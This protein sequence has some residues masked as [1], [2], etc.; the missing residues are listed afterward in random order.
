M[1]RRNF[2][3]AS[4]LSATA[5]M[6]GSMAS[7]AALLHSQEVNA[8]TNEDYKALV[9]VFLYG[10]MDNHDTIIPYDN[11]SYRQ[12]AQ[13]R[14]SLLSSYQT[15]RTR[16]NLLPLVSSASRFGERRFA[17]PPEMKGLQQLYQQGSMAVMGNVGP[18]LE[19]TS[20]DSINN[21]TAKL[22]ARLF[23]HND[24]QST[25]MS[26]TTEGAQLGW[27]GQLNDTL[28]QSGQQSVSTFSAITTS[29]AELLLTGAQ[30]TPFHVQGG[31]AVS[32]DI[33]DESDGALQAQLLSHFSAQDS[34]KGALIKRDLATKNN[35][36]YAANALYNQALSANSGGNIQM[37]RSRLGNQLGAVA[38]TI[39]ARSQ[40][41]SKRQIFM[42]ALGGFDTHSEQAQSLPGLQKMLDEAIVGFYQNM[43]A[44]DLADK[45]TLFTA[46]DFGRTLAVNGDGT[47][48]GWGAHHFVVGG[49]VNGGHIYGDIPPATFNHALDAGSG[50]LIPTTS[51]EQYAANFGAWLGLGE[52]ELASVF[53]NL[54][55]FNERPTLFQ[56]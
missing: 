37:P 38:K 55:N 34:N 17:L 2:L 15:P 54:A 21:E 45:V 24:Q 3:K 19:T 42:V 39:N 36:A 33:L 50:R 35:Q 9:C 47:D 5:A 29:E 8:N 53:P 27:A 6:T 1:N 41:Q 7:L 56:T 28:I 31:S 14:S 20:A 25:W 18:L 13:I 23:S 52:A 43:V 12:W 16:E 48:H 10:G 26:G 11:D 46:S 51:V 22:P 4:S 32:L 30:T 40:L 49:A 44:M